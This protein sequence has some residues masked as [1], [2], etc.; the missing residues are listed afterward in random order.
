MEEIETIIKAIA[1][2]PNMAIWALVIFYGYKVVVIGSVYGLIRFVVSKGVDAYTSSRRQRIEV[3][4]DDVVYYDSKERLISELRRVIP[5][6]IKY[7]G[8]NTD[9]ALVWLNDAI[10]QKMEKDGP[11][12]K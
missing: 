7:S 9:S 5:A 6:D 11:P 4:I 12:K 2:L 8:T 10:T 3:A 1:G